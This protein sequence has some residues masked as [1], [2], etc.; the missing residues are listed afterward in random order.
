MFLTARVP[1]VKQLFF[2]FFA[3]E[4]NPTFSFLV[5]TV[6][7]VWVA[8]GWWGEFKLGNQLFSISSILRM[9][10]MYFSLKKAKKAKE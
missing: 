9:I 10:L 6:S 8:A 4:P 3:Q 1:D 5:G 2:F 7:S